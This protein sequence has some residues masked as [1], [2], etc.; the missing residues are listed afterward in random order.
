MMLRISDIPI[1]ALDLETGGLIPGKHTPLSIGAV[2]L[3]SPRLPVD[4]TN[5]FYAQLEWPV[6]VTTPEAMK[7][8]KL[9][10]TNPPGP[11]DT[12]A[13]R[14]YPVEEAMIHF[15]QW[16][17][18]RM[19][20]RFQVADGTIHALGFNVGSF[21]LPMLRSIWR[22]FPWPFHYRSID[23]NSLFFALSQV[24][25][26]PYSAVKE[27][28]VKQA[29]AKSEFPG[30]EHNALADAWMAVYA[31]DECIRRFNGDCEVLC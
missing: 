29:W 2:W 11:D 5:S 12:L 18:N 28:V 10:L 31:W 22:D 24:Q 16:L 7:V 1:L 21:D 17:Y 26:K 30:M 4:E 6:Y 3:N 9:N 20:D 25:N 13:N 23:L 15:K 19:A 8:N 27:E 14:S